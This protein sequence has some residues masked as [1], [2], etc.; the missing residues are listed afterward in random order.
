MSATGTHLIDVYRWY[1]GEPARVGGGMTSPVYN[2]PN[3]EIATLVFDYPDRMLAEFTAAAILPKA[4]R[5]EI[6]GDDGLLRSVAV[7]SAGWPIP[8]EPP[9]TTRSDPISGPVGFSAGE[10]E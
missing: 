4:N 2:S 3:E 9:R 8:H 1:F 7:S 6:H 10:T 5:L